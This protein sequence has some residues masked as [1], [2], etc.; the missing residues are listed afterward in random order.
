MEDVKN[1]DTVLVAGV[2]LALVESCV[3]VEWGEV[4]VRDSLM[5]ENF[6]FSFD[7]SGRGTCVFKSHPQSRLWQSAN[8][9]RSS[10]VMS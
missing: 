9:Y 7:S 10:A 1:V 6:L 5:H 8:K 4:Y 3:D 2:Q